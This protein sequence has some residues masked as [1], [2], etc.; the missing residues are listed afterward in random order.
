MRG[1]GEIR[2]GFFFFF[3]GKNKNKG[4]EREKGNEGG[5]KKSEDFK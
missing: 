4:N 1:D 3:V 5:R 2:V